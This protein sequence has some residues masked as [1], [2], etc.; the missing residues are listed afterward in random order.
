[1]EAGVWG[2]KW[3]NC[4]NAGSR[5]A[6]ASTLSASLRLFHSTTCRV[7]IL[8]TPGLA[9]G[10]LV[11]C[12]SLN[13]QHCYTELL[14]CRHGAVVGEVYP[15]QASNSHAFRPDHTVQHA[16]VDHHLAAGVLPDTARWTTTHPA[17][18]HT[19]TGAGSPGAKVAGADLI[20]TFWYAE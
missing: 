10:Q 7:Q 13:L 9:A 18:R 5:K 2:W 19:G 15:I 14:A 20:L 4:A 8:H 12:Q 16:Y 17:N 11:T 3:P 1:M 6:K